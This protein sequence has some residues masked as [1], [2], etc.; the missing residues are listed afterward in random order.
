MEDRW[1]SDPK[2]ASQ[3][4]FYKL[5]GQQFVIVTTYKPVPDTQHTIFDPTRIW[6]NLSYLADVAHGGLSGPTIKLYEIPADRR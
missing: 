1:D 3:Q 2:Y 5:L 4:N 6:R